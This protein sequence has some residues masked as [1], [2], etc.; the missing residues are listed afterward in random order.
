MNEEQIKELL[1]SL[2]NSKEFCLKE[3]KPVK[4]SYDKEK[5]HYYNECKCKDDKHHI[6]R[7]EITGAIRI[8]KILI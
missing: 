8:L 5:G 3:T 1:K 2:K 4:L 6:I 7:E